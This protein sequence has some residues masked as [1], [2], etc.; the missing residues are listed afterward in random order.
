MYR[1]RYSFNELRSLGIIPFPP[2]LLPLAASQK[3]SIAEDITHFGQKTWRTR[4]GSDPK[5]SSLRI[6]SHSIYTANR[7]KH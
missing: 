5:V 4:A 2:K 6:N 3:L 1:C 7:A